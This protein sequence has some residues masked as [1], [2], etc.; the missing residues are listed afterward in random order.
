MSS[1]ASYDSA[2]PP[3]RDSSTSDNRNTPGPSRLELVQKAL[4]A[5]FNHKKSDSARILSDCTCFRPFSERAEHFPVD[6]VADHVV[7]DERNSADSHSAVAPVIMTP[8]MINSASTANSRPRAAVNHGTIGRSRVDFATLG[9]APLRLG[10]GSRRVTSRD[11]EVMEAT[12]ALLNAEVPEPDGVAS[13][14]SLLRGFNATIPSAEQSRTRRRQMRSVDAPH[15]G[16]K[17]LGMNARGLLTEDDD[18][19]SV[20]SE[21]DVV[22]VPRVESGQK[23][24]KRRGRESLSASKVLGKDELSRQTKEILRDKENLHVRRVRNYSACYP[25]RADPIT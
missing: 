7:A 11:L 12:E 16:L 10:M 14:V 17:K 3:P 15:L 9:R 21:D 6:L 20:T 1:R 2:R 23:G 24:K 8:R 22:M 5:P 13:N 19:H 25:F 18:G 4:L